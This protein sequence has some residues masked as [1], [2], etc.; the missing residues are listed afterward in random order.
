MTENGGGQGNRDLA[1]DLSR[2]AEPFAVFEP[3]GG[4]DDVIPSEQGGG[5]PPPPPHP[6][7]DTNWN[8]GLGPITPLGKLGLTFF[9]LDA[10][11]QLIAVSA[12]EIKKSN[13][14]AM[15]GQYSD[16]LYRAFPRK[17]MKEDGSWE[18]IGWKAEDYTQLI[19]DEAARRGVWDPEHF[20][21]GR[22]CWR[23]GDGDVLLFAGDRIQT[24]RRERPSPEGTLQKFIID[25]VK[26]G[27]RGRHVFP[28]AP[29]LPGLPADMNLKQARD[30]V[31][32][33]MVLL[34]SWN[35]KRPDLDPHLLLGWI[36]CANLSGALPWRPA[37][38]IT[39]GKGTG[40][41]TLQ[42][43]IKCLGGDWFVDV[44]DATGA[45][46][47]QALQRDARAVAID[48][49]E[50][51]ADETSRK[52]MNDVIQLARIAASGG[53]LRRGG[54]RHKGIEFEA[55]S[56]F[57]FS[58]ILVPPLT[59][60]DRSRLAI[61]ELNELAH[62]APDIVIDEKK[63]AQIGAAIRLLAIVE[64]D[65]YGD[66]LRA[67]RG[68]LARAGH[69]ARGCDQFGALLAGHDLAVC[70]RVPDS[71]SL[72]GWA[73][74]V[75]QSV[76]VETSE[77]QPDEVECLFRLLSSSVSRYRGGDQLTVTELISAAVNEREPEFVENNQVALGRIGLAIRLGPEGM[78]QCL[79]VSNNHEGLVAIY[80]GSRWASGVWVQSLRRLKG[81]VASA[82][83]VRIGGLPPQ[84]CT[85]IPIDQVLE[86]KASGEGWR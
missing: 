37:A 72:A 43:L 29:E 25:S 52:R 64:W 60:Q 27:P 7:F 13:L 80:A 16:W 41:S 17:K 51:G 39:G 34:K 86:R 42:L 79:F 49:A 45:G 40:K 3:L 8:N 15:V 36:V 62:D 84:R 19:M 5:E 75:Q 1:A 69:N 30:L 24:I 67:F 78:G 9:M 46:V 70:D 73:E 23:D 26:P 14:L 28:A 4:V 48:E 10:A 50:P 31:A 57:L 58:S 83:G 12:S 74:M 68:M 18:T 63:W 20:A 54:D 33:L 59:P 81:A 66:T 85:L 61:F 56:C 82:A 6:R 35:W 47:W 32:E 22:G 71:D 76:M 55:R 65:R 77:A 44:A 53:T 11:Q 2:A 38:W 21:H